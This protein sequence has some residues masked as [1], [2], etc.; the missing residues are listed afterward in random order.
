LKKAADKAGRSLISLSFAWLLH[1]TSTD[2]AIV[3][4]SSRKQLKQNLEACAE[5]PLSDEIVSEC[6]RI[7]QD[8]RGP[9]PSYNR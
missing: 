9:V 7:W 1:H 8:F 2:I 6:D 3:G 4:A 5:G